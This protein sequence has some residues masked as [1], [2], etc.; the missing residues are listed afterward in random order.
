[1]N[2]DNTENARRL[3]AALQGFILGVLLA[4]AV[5]G[6]VAASSQASVFRYQGY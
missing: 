2:N 1:M 6:L 4:I 3:G 5:I